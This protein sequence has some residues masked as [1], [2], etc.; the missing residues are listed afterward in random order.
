MTISRSIQAA[1]NDLISLFF[2][3]ES[4]SLE[5]FSR[6]ITVWSLSLWHLLPP[7]N[8]KS[9]NYKEFFRLI[10]ILENRTARH[11]TKNNVFLKPSTRSHQS[12]G[13]LRPLNQSKGTGVAGSREEE[14]RL[15]SATTS[16]TCNPTGSC[17]ALAQNGQSKYDKGRAENI[18]QKLCSSLSVKATLPRKFL[19]PKV[20]VRCQGL[21]HTNS[22]A[23]IKKFSCFLTNFTHINF[24]WMIKRYNKKHIPS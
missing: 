14:Q 13:R 2:M 24:P 21:T 19:V 16:K 23:H 12:P 18:L 4:Y 8:K 22:F 7:S 3:T 5:S 11:Y 15:K 9:Q 17:P 10:M 20:P 6:Y 1:A